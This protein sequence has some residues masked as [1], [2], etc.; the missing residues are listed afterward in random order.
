LVSSLCNPIGRADTYTDLDLLPLP[1]VL[2]HTSLLTHSTLLY[3]LVNVVGFACYHFGGNSMCPN[4]GGTCNSYPLRYSKM[5]LVDYYVYELNLNPF[6][7]SNALVKMDPPN[8]FTK[9]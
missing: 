7:H 9:H 4:L 6:V 8:P 5:S 2:D 3:E 1:I